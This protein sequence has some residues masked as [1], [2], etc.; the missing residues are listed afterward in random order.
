MFA[1]HISEETMPLIKEHQ[2]T[3]P[4]GVGRILESAYLTSLTEWYYIQGYVNNNGGVESWAAFPE[5]ILV[6]Q[7]EYDPIKIQTDWDQIVRK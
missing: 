3:L 5:Y 2:D 4:S 7:F 6:R 1:I